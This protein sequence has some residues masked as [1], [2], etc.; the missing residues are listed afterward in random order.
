MT[1][2]KDLIN[3]ISGIVL[4]GLV[5]IM[6]TAYLFNIES[7]NGISLFY[8]L[9]LAGPI[10]FVWFG[11]RKNACGSCNQDCSISKIGSEKRFSK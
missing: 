5:T 10:F 2:L 4:L 8:L 11:T 3:K 6:I 1:H 9:Y 7:K